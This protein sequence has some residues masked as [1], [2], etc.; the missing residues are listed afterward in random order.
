VNR[1]LIASLV[2]IGPLMGALMVMGA[3]P[4]GADRYAWLVI[5]LTSAFI[6][7]RREPRRALKH[8]ALIGFSNG[9]AA[10]LVQA[11]FVEQLLANNP[12]IAEA[13][14]R[15]PKGFDM[16]FFLFMLVP[17][18]GVAGAAATGWLAILFV[19]FLNSR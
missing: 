17:F 18:I 4:K 16:E 13:F 12:W 11:F 6:V 5:V 9:A 1:R 2:W 7:A 15:Q 8:A 10:T 19:R 3:F 14:A